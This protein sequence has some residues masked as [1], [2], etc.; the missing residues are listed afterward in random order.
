MDALSA[1]IAYEQKL[2]MRLSSFYCR[3]LSSKMLLFWVSVPIPLSGALPIRGDGLRGSYNGNW[4]GR[5]KNSGSTKGARY[6]AAHSSTRV[7]TQLAEIEGF[8]LILL[9]FAVLTD[10]AAVFWGHVALKG[11]V[12]LPVW[13][14][15]DPAGSFAF[16]YPWWATESLSLVCRVKRVTYTFSVKASLCITATVICFEKNILDLSSFIN[17]QHIKFWYWYYSRYN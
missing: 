13:R 3:L 7:H 15:W 17:Q 11:F 9:S 12:P 8:Q 1:L 14:C 4:V 6:Q 2:T 5:W 10:E 16:P